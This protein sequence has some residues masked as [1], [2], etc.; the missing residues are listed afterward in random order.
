MTPRDVEKTITQKLE[1]I[2]KKN[3]MVFSIEFVDT[4]LYKLLYLV[5]FFVQPTSEFYKLFRG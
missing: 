4:V 3:S 1:P 5:A 2:F